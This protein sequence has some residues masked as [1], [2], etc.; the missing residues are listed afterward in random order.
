MLL[1]F[2]P[3]TRIILIPSDDNSTHEFAISRR[4]LVAMAT[5]AATVTVLLL[6]VVLSYAN[7]LKQARRVPELQ[8]QL[9]TANAQLV[10][11][12]ELNLE[13]EEMRGL[14]ERLLTML[15]VSQLAPAEVDSLRAA[16]G[17][18]GEAAGVIMTPPP[19][20]WP[21]VG[22]VTREFIE[23]DLVNG[24]T[25]HYGI[26]LVAPA[27]TPI[28]AAGRGVVQNVGWDDALGNYVEIRH[29]FGYVT[30]YAHCSRL[31]VQAGD[32]VD[33]GQAVALLGGT[34]RATAPHLH[35]EIWRDGEAVDPRVVIPGD[36]EAPRTTG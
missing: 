21:L 30:I 31:L 3:H 5:L 7:L 25:P 27:D 2:P 33:A 22:Q 23:G 19:D 1:R 32:R 16:T 34:G 36:P 29:G 11:V 4:L 14:Q 13:L 6:L 24:V 17:R 12:Q 26:D 10:Q 9:V 20:V 15:G 18:L 28:R 8:A 35:F